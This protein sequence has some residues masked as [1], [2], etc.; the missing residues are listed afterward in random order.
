MVSAANRMRDETLAQFPDARVVVHHN[1]ADNIPP[2]IA[3]NAR[4]VELVG[5]TVIAS[6]GIFYDRKNFP[7]L[8][9]A[10]GKVAARHPNLVLRICGDGPVRTTVDDAVKESGAA[11]RITL[12]GM[13][14]HRPV[15]PEI[16]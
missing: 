3:E 9:R 8:I 15:L 5:K 11:D 12:L 6:T 4:P 14:P 10:F 2:E 1:G 7:M 16:D 13:Q